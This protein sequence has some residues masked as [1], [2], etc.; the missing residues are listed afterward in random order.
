MRYPVFLRDGETIG[1]VAPSFGCTIEPYKS[2]YGNAK[3][4][5]EQMGYRVFEGENCHKDDG[6]GISSSPESCGRELCDVYTG[7]DCDVIVSCGGGELMCEILPF[8]DF[9]KI[10]DSK[11]KWFLGYSDNTNFT[12]TL[13]VLADTAAIYG[14][15]AP[16]FGMKKW[17]KALRDAWDIMTGKSLEVAG[18]DLWERESLKSPENPLE[19]YNVTEKKKLVLQMG[20]DKADVVKMKGRMIGGCLDTLLTLIGTDYD[21]TAEFI[22]RY[23]GDGIIWFLEACDLSVFQIRRGLWQMK[24]AGWFDG[25]TGF[26]FGRP[27]HFDEPEM[28]LDRHLAVN[29]HLADLGVPV[30]MDA[31]LG[32]LPPAMPIISG[33]VAEI[34]AEGD[35]VSIKYH[36][37]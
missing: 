15:C 6:I 1:F 7:K 16:T 12:Y 33:A 2:A 17:H 34:E 29:A 18:Y 3:D 13:N 35:D 25:A 11:P 30:I 28:G 31:D 19:P 14:P 27:Y 36:M 10:K 23:R 20:G 9:E 26:L 21:K 24:K 37:V 22:K 4:T 32:H 5:F 8:I